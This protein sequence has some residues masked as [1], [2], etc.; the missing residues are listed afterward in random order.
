M[1]SRTCLWIM[2]VLASATAGGFLLWT[3]QLIWHVATEIDRNP[4]RSGVK[5]QLML[6]KSEAMH[7]ILDEMIAGNLDRVHSAA[8]RMER[9][10]K[11]IDGYLASEPYDKYGAI[12]PWTLDNLRTS[13]RLRKPPCV[14]NS[15]VSNATC[16]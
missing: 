11:T 1:K 5:S 3:A 13:T 4:S 14:W 16:C 6:R 8:K 12:F 10:G 7:D 2:I 15:R 9:Y